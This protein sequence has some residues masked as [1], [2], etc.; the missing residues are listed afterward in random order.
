MV[1]SH[2]RVNLVMTL[3]NVSLLPRYLLIC[4]REPER[5]RLFG[6]DRYI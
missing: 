6:P 4:A 3:S 1:D 5:A 2:R